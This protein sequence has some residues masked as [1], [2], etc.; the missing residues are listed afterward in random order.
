MITHA[1]PQLDLPHNVTPANLETLLNGLLE[2]NEKL[3]YSFFVEEQQL[4]DALGSHLQK[5]KVRSLPSVGI[6]VACFSQRRR[7]V[8]NVTVRLQ[9]SVESVLK[10]VFQP[11]AVF[12]VRP[13]A[14]CTASMQG[15]AESVLVVSFSPN[16]MYL[17]SGSGDTTVR[18][19]DLGTQTPKHTCKV[20]HR[21]EASFW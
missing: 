4:S 14:R 1:G 10:V 17:A 6:R 12:R 5:H 8:L 20:G 7:V 3:P 15:H 21:M 9:V 11:Q 16:G 2:Q 13:V 19:W 18:L